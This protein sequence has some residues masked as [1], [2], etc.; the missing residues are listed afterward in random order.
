MVKVSRDSQMLESAALGEGPTGLV[1]TTAHVGSWSGR[2]GKQ[3]RY[4]LRGGE[5]PF[6]HWLRWEQG[7]NNFLSRELRFL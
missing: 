7:T 3:C 5:V 2:S 1:L 6:L 4:I